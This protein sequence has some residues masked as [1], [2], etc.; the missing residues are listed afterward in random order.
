MRKAF[1]I[2]L[3]IYL[4]F[5]GL[6]PARAQ[7]AAH[8]D[9]YDF[10]TGLF[11]A[12]SAG[13][14]VF[15]SA[16]NFVSGLSPDA[17]TLLEDDRPR[18]LDKL[19]ELQPGVQFALALDPG[20]SFAYRDVNAV[21]RYDK[22]YKVLQEWAATH[23]DNLGDDL[24]LVPTDGTLSAH[25]ATTAAFSDALKAYSPALQVIKPS[26]DT[27]SR[28]LDTV[29]E[30]APQPGMK[31]TVLFISSPPA[32]DAIPT[33]QNLT[34]RAV[35]QQV[36]VNVWI[37]V[38]ADFFATSGATALKDLA[39]QTG[40]QY[41]LFSGE[42]PLPGLE[43]YLASL[44][45][46]YRLGYTSAVTTSGGHTLAAQVNL[47][48]ETVT[49]TVL[50]FDLNIQPPNPILVTPPDQIVR[51]APDEHTTSALAFLPSQ[52][53]IEILVEFPDGRTRPLVRTVL[54]VDNQK[55]A[56]NTSTPFDRF[57]WDLS[58]YAASGQH[59]LSVEAVDNLGLSKTSLGV[60]VM[61]TIIRPPR[62]LLPFLSRN[63]QWVV[64]GAVLFSGTI[65]GVILASGR[66]RRRI[67]PSNRDARHD[68]LT[69]PVQSAKPVRR[70]PLLAWLRP[71][72]QSEAYLVRLREDGEPMTAPPV[73]V[74]T[75][76][77]IFGS[78]PLQA[79]RILDDPS[80]SPL[81]ARLKEENGEYILSDEKSVAG[82]W[83]N[84]EQL[85]AP[86]RLQHGDVLQIGQ[87]SYRF[88]LR[89]PPERHAP[90]VAPTKP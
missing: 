77:M 50:P 17:I 87:F 81:H 46:T 24:S 69:Q 59:I 3:S 65:L 58:G 36:R 67:R 82:T 26:L 78:D 30:T 80:V 54:Y 1:I 5:A 9:L 19:E 83:V 41:V 71:V 64:L 55:V 43:T 42:E 70:K 76:E 4:L 27:L 20:P 10:Q 12:M 13:L 90:R 68:P 79:T 38:S 7:S 11:P 89:K 28:A 33:L 53:T 39:I 21:T 40:G 45:H 52:Q 18:P 88:M 23:P 2:F 29:S 14:D 56:E 16:G 44:R 22:I 72:K 61:V 31:P 63:R 48:G 49:S 35:A 74:V 34:E 75:P 86:L 85:V 84:Y 8:I 66:A 51:Q 6:A 25:L 37:V 57:S 32:Q 47:N 60:P 62:G 73:P 15:D